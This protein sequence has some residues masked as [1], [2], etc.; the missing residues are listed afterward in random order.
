MTAEQVL[1]RETIKAA[2]Q[3]DPA[4]AVY[5]LL[6]WLTTRK[7]TLRLGSSEDAAPAARAAEAFCRANGLGEPAE[8]S[9]PRH[10]RF[11]PSTVNLDR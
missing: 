10:L 11:P 1:C 5:G 2:A 3:L 4:G 6:A 8:E 9:Y 7:G